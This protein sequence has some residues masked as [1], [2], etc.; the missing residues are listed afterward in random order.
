MFQTLDGLVK[1]AL[2]AELLNPHSSMKC[3]GA[4]ASSGSVGH[5]F[6]HTSFHVGVWTRS[7]PGSSRR[8]ATIRGPSSLSWDWPH[9]LHRAWQGRTWYS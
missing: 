4:A 8:A 2:V 5:R 9:S 1:L 6:V 7:E 3:R